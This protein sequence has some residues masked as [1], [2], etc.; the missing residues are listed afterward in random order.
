[1]SSDINVAIP[2]EGTP[3][4][5]VE[6]RNNF[7]AAKAEIESLQSLIGSKRE[8]LTQD[9]NYYVSPTGS[10]ANNG[11]SIES[12]FL[13]IQ[14]AIDVISGT[15]DCGNHEVTIQL[16]EGTYTTS[17]GVELKN[18][19]ASVTPVI[20]GESGKANTT[21]INTTGNSAAAIY[22]KTISTWRIENLKITTSGAGSNAVYTETPGALIEVGNNVIFGTCLNGIHAG[23]FDGSAIRFI[24]SYQINGGAYAHLF[25]GRGGHVIAIPQKTV[26]LNGAPSFNT[27]AIAEDN[28][29]CT[30]INTTF[31]GSALGKRF[32]CNNNGIIQTYGRGTLY[33]PGS[34]AGTTSTNGIYM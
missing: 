11:L 10:D 14:K 26:T 32:Q 24:S 23:A 27:F 17:L 8:L 12:P 31:T 19:I 30:H 2:V 15:I 22:S 1:M 21:I 28:G 7:A 6:I 9:R 33:F 16:K 29:V 5:A 20:K 25:A 18:V 3:A 4:D 13:T 34:L